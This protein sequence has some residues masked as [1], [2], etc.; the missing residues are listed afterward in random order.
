MKQTTLDAVLQKLNLVDP[1]DDEKQITGRKMDE[2]ILNEVVVPILGGKPEAK[3]IRPWSEDARDQGGCPFYS[4][5]VDDALEVVELMLE[6]QKLA[7]AFY[8]N[9]RKLL[10]ANKEDCALVKLFLHQRPAE[11]ICIAALLAV[12]GKTI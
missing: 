12:R 11:A 8:Q 10:D 1:D 4:T 6:K 5:S 9:V 7:V 3:V 2:L